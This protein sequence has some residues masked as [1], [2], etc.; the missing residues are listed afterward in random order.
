M[1]IQ[2]AIALEAVRAFVE[3]IE[4]RLLEKHNAFITSPESAEVYLA[5]KAELAAMEAEV[6]G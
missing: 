5:L 6:K 3:R 1:K 4:K 2:R